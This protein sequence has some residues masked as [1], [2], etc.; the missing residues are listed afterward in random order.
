MKIMRVLK[1]EN[2]KYKY[3]SVI[4]AYVFL[5]IFMG[6]IGIFNSSFFSG[7]NMSNLIYTAF[8]LMMVAFGQTLCL[9]TGGLDIS[10]GMILSLSNCVCIVLMKPEEPFGW[11]AAVIAAL[12]VGAACGILNGVLIS[13]FGLTPM[14]TTL[15]TSTIYGGIALFL[16]PMPG[17]EVHVGFAKFLR[18]KAGPIP[19]VLFLL[20]IVLAAVR[21][22]SNATP[23][24]KKIRAAGGNDTA[25]YA[26]G[27][28]VIRA[29]TSAYMIAGIL[30]AIGGIFMAAYMYSGDPTIGASYSLRAI[31]SS[32]IGGTAFSGALGDVLGTFAGVIILTLI[33]NMLNLLGV[34]SYFQ[35]LL[36]GIIIIAALTLGS[37]RKVD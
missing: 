18:G 12:I 32:I 4:F 9:L 28:N 29:K 27:I 36:Q 14:I 3:S 23:L 24:G 8:P 15:A 34:S 33:N 7:R 10:L 31:A 6:F 25:A 35:F 30:S 13:R 37:L 16:L 17:G 21:M 1:N 26:T 2:F 20:L 11:V 19:L 5:L 22:I